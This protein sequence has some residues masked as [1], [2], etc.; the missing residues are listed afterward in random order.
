MALLSTPIFF[1][2]CQME[3][4]YS[5]P[6]LIV[7]ATVPVNY[8]LQ[9]SAKAQ[10]LLVHVESRKKCFGP[11]LDSWLIDQPDLSGSN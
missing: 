10:Q 5:G 3:K 2:V 11:T 7:R 8:F 9:H 4:S 6:S 1:Q